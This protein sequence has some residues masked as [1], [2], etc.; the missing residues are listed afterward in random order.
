MQMNSQPIDKPNNFDGKPNSA[1]H[2]VVE[3]YS[4]WT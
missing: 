3:S 4:Q 1:V 2:F